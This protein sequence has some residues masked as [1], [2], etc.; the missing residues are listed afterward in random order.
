MR[1]LL[2]INILLDVFLARNAW[3]AESAAVVQSNFDGKTTSYLSAASLP[4]I[5]YIVR[6]NANL[7]RAHAVIK[8]CLDTFSILPVDRAALGIGNRISGLR[9]RR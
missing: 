2:D 9:L 4:T 3:L 5:F 6:R 7:A 1:V 8:E